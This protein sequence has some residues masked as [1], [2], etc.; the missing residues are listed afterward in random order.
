MSVT[1]RLYKLRLTPEVEL[2]AADGMASARV[3]CSGS[4]T[5]MWTCSGM[6]T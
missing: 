4:L 6:I 5:G 2:V 3:S 1:K